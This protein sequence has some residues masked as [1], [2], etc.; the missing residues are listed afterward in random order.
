MTDFQSFDALAFHSC[1]RELG[2]RIVNGNDELRPSN[3]EWDWLGPGIYF[4]EQDPARALEYA[5]DAAEGKQKNKKAPETPFVV[6]AVVQLGNCL[7]LVES[8]A[9]DILSAAYAGLEELTGK[10]GVPML[11]NRGK[12][13][14]L[15]CAV[16][17]YIHEAN[18]QAG[19]Q[20]YDTIRCAFPEGDAAYP[21]AMISKRLHIQICVCNPD[22]IKGYFLPR[23]IEKFNP[24]L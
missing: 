23:P 8:T 20:S 3:N 12:N 7:N 2:L 19:K 15:D 22:M 1:D 11:A 18:R 4:W 10:M 17:K 21:G 14:A 16:I 9:L 24:H 5:T 13:R 6:G